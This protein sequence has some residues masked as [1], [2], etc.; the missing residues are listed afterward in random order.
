MAQRDGNQDRHQE[1]GRQLDGQQEPLRTQQRKRSEHSTKE[2]AQDEPLQEL[3]FFTFGAQPAKDDNHRKGKHGRPVPENAPLVEAFEEGPGHGIAELADGGVRVDRHVVEGAKRPNG[4]SKDGHGE[5][6]ETCESQPALR[7][8]CVG[9]EDDD[10]GD[11]GDFRTRPP[12]KRQRADPGLRI[13]M[14]ADLAC[15]HIAVTGGTEAMAQR[16]DQEEPAEW[17]PGS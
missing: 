5:A 14:A 15:D 3:A 4:E 7:P 11:D 1:N 12:V 2:I 16:T 6:K 13:V 9:V 8:P 10:R 17:I